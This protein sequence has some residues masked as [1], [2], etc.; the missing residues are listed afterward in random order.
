MQNKN[1]ISR[2]KFKNWAFLVWRCHFLLY[3]RRISSGLQRGNSEM[4][5]MPYSFL[6]R[7]FPQFLSFAFFLSRSVG[8]IHDLPFFQVDAGSGQC[9]CTLSFP[10]VVFFFFFFTSFLLLFAIFFAAVYTWP[11]SGHWPD[12]CRWVTQPSARISYKKPHIYSPENY[13]NRFCLTSSYVRVSKRRC[14][15]G[16]NWLR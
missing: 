14:C 5:F 9:V 6:R 3:R 7:S 4:I 15:G 12:I 10:F 2:I 8:Y 1:W 11:I 13:I 16:V